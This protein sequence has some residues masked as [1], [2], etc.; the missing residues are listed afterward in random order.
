MNTF[1]FQKKNKNPSACTRQLPVSTYRNSMSAPTVNLIKLT[2]LNLVKASV[3]AQITWTSG[4]LA[5]TL[6]STNFLESQKYLNITNARKEWGLWTYAY[7]L[8]WSA[9]PKSSH[10]LISPWCI[11][12]RR[13]AVKSFN[14]CAIS[15]IVFSGACFT[16]PKR[17]I[18]RW[19]KKKYTT[20]SW[21]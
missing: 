14:L 15:T 21:R 7:N 9:L 5:T 18:K 12:T 6:F 10:Q 19:L 1:Y 20:T 3:C 4:M 17:R 13:F 2:T 8:F 16:T 11:R